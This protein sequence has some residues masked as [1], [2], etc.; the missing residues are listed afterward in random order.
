MKIEE[1]LSQKNV[2]FFETNTGKGDVRVSRL[3][4]KG[5]TCYNL[6][7]LRTMIRMRQGDLQ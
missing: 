1:Q 6:S 7:L 4:A 5:L 2:I 3:C